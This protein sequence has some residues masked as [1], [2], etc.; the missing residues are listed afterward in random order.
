MDLQPIGIYSIPE[1]S[2]VGATEKR[3]DPRRSALRGRRI[4]LPG[5]GPRPDRRDSYG[6]LKLLVSTDDLRLLGGTSSVPT[7][8]RWST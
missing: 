3:T 7:P 2:Y 4:P 8:P 1:I 5:A 6:M